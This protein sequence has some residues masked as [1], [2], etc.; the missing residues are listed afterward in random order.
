MTLDLMYGLEQEC[1]M[2]LEMEKPSLL[3]I[4]SVMPL[5]KK[6]LIPNLDLVY[7]LSFN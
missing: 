5:I 1:H 7:H 4:P 6:I 2:K 3:H